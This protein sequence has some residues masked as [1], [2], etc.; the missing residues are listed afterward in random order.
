MVIVATGAAGTQT[1]PASGLALDTT[2]T[3]GAATLDRIVV[4]SSA[5][6]TDGVG[7]GIA[8]A[9]PGG[10]AWR[11]TVKNVAGNVLTLVSAA[12]QPVLNARVT[13]DDGA[14]I[15]AAIDSLGP[16]G[17]VVSIPAGT[18]VV[19]TPRLT[20]PTIPYGQP[21]FQTNVPIFTRG[22]VTL[23]GEG[24][25]KTI[26]R[27]CDDA[28]QISIGLASLG[29][30]A[31][32]YPSGSLIVNYSHPWWHHAQPY[33]S[34]AKMD[35]PDQAIT[36]EDFTL[37]GNNLNQRAI[38]IPGNRTNSAVPDAA[39]GFYP[40]GST[41]GQP[42][43][44]G[45]QPLVPGTEYWIAMTYADALG[46]ETGSYAPYEVITLLPGQDAI[47]VEMPNPP[48]GAVTQ[49]VYI[50]D[51]NLAPYDSS[52]WPYT[53]ATLASQVWDRQQVTGFAP[54]SAQPYLIVGYRPGKADVP[55][56]PPGIG[57]IGQAQAT[58]SSAIAVDNCSKLV[59]RRLKVKDSIID[60]I[61]VAQNDVVSLDRHPVEDAL[62]EDIEVSGCG[63]NGFVIT[64]GCHNIRFVRLDV[65][66][67]SNG[68]GFDFE[69]VAAEVLPASEILLQDC[70]IHN[71]RWGVGVLW[72][73]D[74]TAPCELHSCGAISMP[75]TPTSVLTGRALTALLSSDAP[76]PTRQ[77]RH[78]RYKALARA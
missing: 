13:S 32:D 50:Q 41:A 3:I 70:R 66:D 2:G 59:C 38:F 21:G 51:S 58:L 57:G 56:Y 30:T 16:D 45:Q 75:T 47:R 18:F 31:R 5:G 67:N 61:T 39:T 71:H 26:L 17:G 37:D 53:V 10:A 9:G 27:L 63:R 76:S 19:G 55:V 23:K 78:S 52:S 68:N 60:G 22:G 33:A 1:F 14:A 54:G 15:Q 20:T 29:S 73:L 12:L 48:V 11:T 40:V 62:F 4:A 42:P 69:P 72:S 77:Q 36:I 43:G 25:G 7:I 49:Y 6:W 74:K 24:A 65:H 28:N 46:N 44:P 64:G 8:G 34:P 35:L